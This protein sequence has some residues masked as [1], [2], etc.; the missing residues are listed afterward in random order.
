MF[1]PFMLVPCL[2]CLYDILSMI[3]PLRFSWLVKILLALLILS[4]PAKMLLLRMTPSG[5]TMP[6]MTRNIALILSAMFSFMITAAILLIIKDAS[7]ILWRIFLRAKFPA[8]YASLTVLII[9]AMSTVY[10]VY[11]GTR[12]PDVIRHDVKISGLG[13]NLDGLK[14]AMLVDIHVGSVN[15][16]EFVEEIVDRTNALSPD[17]ILIPGDFVDGHVKDRKFDLEPLTQLRSKFGVYA[18]T[19]NHEYYYDLHGWLETLSGFGIKFLHNEHTVISSGDSHI[20]IA[21][22]P[23][24]T[25]GN[26]D[27]PRALEDS[28][29]NV[30][31]ILMDH[32]P[33]FARENSKL[34]VAFQVSG[35]THG[36]QIP[37]VYQIT[38][39]FNGGFVRGWYDIGGMKLYVSPGTSQ[40]DGFPMRLF[41]PSE[42]SLFILH[43]E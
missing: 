18:V 13:K 38:R 6:E 20:V 41:D 16:R 2:I 21:G 14:V 28:P 39:R 31:V 5:F 7:M 24:P 1:N 40:W 36:G 29:E 9:A 22:V 10:G 32:Q 8:H 19:G 34:G 12:V 11:Q 4:G 37:V 25:G 30:P 23:D 42:I 15:R 3:I 27:T 17:V 33:R 43:A 35:H 26:H